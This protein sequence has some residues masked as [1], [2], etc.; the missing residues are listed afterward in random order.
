MFKTL[1][2][3]ARTFAAGVNWPMMFYKLVAVAT[4]ALLFGI[5]CY[6]EGKHDCQI[7]TQNHKITVLETE[8]ITERR[9]VKAALN[10][11]TK[12]IN[13]RLG[14]ITKNSGLLAELDSKLEQLKGGLNEAINTR[15]AND[16]CAPSDAELQYY[17]E[18]ARQA[19]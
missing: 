10:K 18:I 3:G 7:E 17:T 12:D 2:T 4:A 14:V 9:E 8:I 13:E 6:R 16:A 5:I 19:N 11:H 15:P 1:L